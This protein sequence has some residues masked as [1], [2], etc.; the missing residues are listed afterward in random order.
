MVF[1]FRRA[2]CPTP[3]PTPIYYAMD[4]RRQ[5]KKIDS[6]L[7]GSV[8][9]KN[10]CCFTYTFSYV[11]IILYLNTGKTLLRPLIFNED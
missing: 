3:G 9:V 5:R 2:S 10:A 1:L 8:E 11:F 6:L 7:P 4:E